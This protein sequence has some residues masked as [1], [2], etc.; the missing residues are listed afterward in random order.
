[1]IKISYQ[2]RR[3]AGLVI[4]FALLALVAVVILRPNPD[5]VLP[6]SH[7]SM[8]DIERLPL[9]E[10]NVLA[11]DYGGLA[12]DE[13]QRALVTRVGEHL[14]TASKASDDGQPFAFYVLADANRINA[15]ALPDGNIFITTLLLNH[16][17]TEGQLA[18]VLAHEIGQIQAHH[19]A[20]YF[21]DRV[22]FTREQEQLAD[23]NAVAILTQGGYDPRALKDVL[24]M[25]RD[26]NETTPV[27]Y[28]QTHPS[29]TNR[30]TRIEYAIC[31]QYPD[32]VP[33][34]LSK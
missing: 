7:E 13:K 27:E 18:A 25:L 33:D 34:V 2:Q 15:F 4:I 17:K 24:L 9:P 26:I 29:P 30:I 14:V 3:L 16:L 28:Y 20:F 12:R 22:T 32:G 6:T 23:A 19:K 21:N 11:R 8:A 1:M 5:D 31:K 10:P